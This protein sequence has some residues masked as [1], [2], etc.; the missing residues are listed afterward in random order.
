MESAIKTEFGG[1]E[2]VDV[3]LRDFVKTEVEEDEMLVK[4]EENEEENSQENDE[5]IQSGDDKAIQKEEDDKEMQLEEESEEETQSDEEVEEMAH[6]EEDGHHLYLKDDLE[7]A[8]EQNG[9]DDNGSD[10]PF[11]EDCRHL[12]A[13]MVIVQMLVCDPI[14]R[15]VHL[16]AKFILR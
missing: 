7:D 12:Y 9:N 3:N 5:A 1:D 13:E 6:S 2:Y 4:M 15:K 14:Q 8:K 16:S 10:E 11:L